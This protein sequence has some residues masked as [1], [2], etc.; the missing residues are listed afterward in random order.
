MNFKL[1]LLT[2]LLVV[3]AGSSSATTQTGNVSA[4][5]SVAEKADNGT[6]GERL[7]TGSGISETTAAIAER[8]RLAPA[9][10]PHP[11]HELEYPDRSNL[12]QNPD[13]PA[14]ASFPAGG[15]AIGSPLTNIHSTTNSFDGATLTD[16]GAFPPDSM[17]TV[18]P[19]QFI[20]FSNGRIRSFTKAGAAD[21]VINANPD[22]FFAS[23]MTPVGGSVVLNFTS[24]PQIRYDRF[25]GRW[26]MSIID[27][28]CTINT[29]AT[30]APNRWLLAVSNAAS[31]GT[32][33]GATVWTFFQFQADASNF[34]DY[35]SLGI[36]VNALYVGCNMFTG[37]GAFVGTNGYVVQK[38]SA[39]GAGPIVVTAFANMAAGA[40]AGP[41]SPRGV[42]NFDASATE[43][44]FVGPD[45]ATF[46]TIMFRR[47]SNPGSLTP[48]IS[49]NIGVAVPT[50]TLSGTQATRLVQHAGNTGGNNGLL[51]SL[52]DRFFQAMIRNGHLWTAHHFTVTN[53]GVA[54][55]AAASRNATR[56]YDFQNLTTTPTLTQ[57]GTVFDNAATRAAARQYWI[58]SITATG[59][60]HAV[61]AFTMGGTP[62]G[63]TPAYTGRLSGDTLGTM[64]GPPGT[65]VVS[66]GTT[67]ANYNPPS[68]PGG[69]SGRRWGDY[70]FTVVDPLDDMSVWTIQE[71][72]QASNSYAVRVGQLLAPPPATPTCSGSPI[73]FPSGTGN[74]VI[75]ATSSAGSGFYDPG[76]NL[77]APALPFN[78]LTASMTNGTVNSATYNSPTQVTLNITA[79]TAGLQNVTITNP[80]GQNVVASGCINVSI[81]THTVTPSSDV[82]GSISPNT[83]VS[84]NDGSTTNFTLTPNASY[85]IASVGGTCGGGLVG[86][87][88]TTAAVT[89]DCT[90]IANFAID[91]FTVTPS[92]TGNG[93]IAPNT[94]QIVNSG[95]T[96]NFTLTPNAGNHIVDVTGTCG[97]GL[98]GNVFTTAAVAANCSVSANFAPDVVGTCGTG[99]QVEAVATAGTPGPTGYTTL[100]GA[101]DAINAGTHQG[102]ITVNVCADTTETASA[103][104]NASG[105]GGS[106]YTGIT[107]NPAGG[108]ARTISGAIA[109]GSPLVDL[110][111]ASNVVI[112]G[113]NSGGNTLTLANTTAAATAG[114][115]TI[116]FI[117]GAKSNT[118]TRTTVLGSSTAAVATAAGN[119]LF[120][121]STVAGGNSGNMISN[122]DF[123]PAGANLPT[124]M[125]SAVGTT[126]NF[127]TNNTIDTNLIHDFFSPTLSVS[128]ISVQAGNSGWAISNNRIYQTAPRTF[129]ATALRYAG[130]TLNGSTTLGNY[131]VTGNIIGFGAAN[132]TGTTTISGSTNTFRGIDT[133]TLNITVPTVISGNFVSGINQTTAG[134]GTTSSAPFVGIMLGSSD[135]LFTATGNQVGSLDGSSTIAVTSNAASLAGWAVGIFNF[136]FQ[137]TTISNNQIGSFALGGSATTAV[138]FRGIYVNTGTGPT[139]LATINNN[140]VANVSSTGIATYALYGIQTVSAPVSITGNLIHDLAGSSSGAGVSGTG[141]GVATT[142]TGA[143]TVARNVLHTLR[144]DAGAASNSI[145]S[146]DLSF[147]TTS[148]NVV[149]RN[150]VH[151]IEINSTTLTSQTAGIVARAGAATYRNNIVRLGVDHNGNSITPGYVMYGIFDNATSNNFYNN[152]V[153]IGGSGVASASNTFALVSNVAAA[154]RTYVDN[155]LWNARSNASG[156]AKN[157]AISLAAIAGATTNYNDLYASGSGGIT[158]ALAGVDQATLANWQAATTQDANSIAADPLFAAPNGTAATVDLHL[159]SG[160]PASGAGTPLAGVVDDFDGDARPAAS[161]AIGAD[162]PPPHTVTPSV[163]TAAGSI[164][165]STPQIVSDGGTPS[166]TLTP[167]PGNHI[168]DVTGTCGGSLVGNVFT[169]DRVTADCTVIANFAADTV[170]H[171]VTPSA[172]AN[173]SITPNTPV[174]VND[175]DT[176]NFTLTP[177]ASYRIASVGGTCGGSLVGNLYTTNPVTADCTVIANFV[178]DTYTVTPSSGGN[179]T[180]SPNTPQVVNN[181][182][183]TGFTLTPN[184]HY[185]IGSVTGTC[186]GSLAGNVFTT[187]AVTADCTVIANFA[188]DTYTVTTNA[189]GGSGTIT[190][191]SQSVDYGSAANFVLTPAAGY[192]VGSVTGNS[193]TV[194]HTTGN[195]WVSSPITANCSVTA[196]FAIDKFTV[197]ASVSG[198]NGTITPASQLVSSGSTAN[199]V[200][201]PAQGYHVASVVGDTCTVT[202]DTGNNWVSSAITTDCAVT[203]TFGLNVLVFTT[204][205]VDVTQGY[206]LATVVVTEEDGSGNP[207]SDSSTVDFT[208]TACGGP[209][210]IGSVAMVNGVATLNSSQVF[211]TVATGLTITATNIDTFASTASAG[212]NVVVNGDLV[213]ADGFES[214]RL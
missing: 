200:V 18:G 92:V 20:V 129:T 103:A 152:S 35:P 143:S 80:D 51:D 25:T 42:D 15:P 127:N 166:F 124:K 60:G 48:T 117:E 154:A 72:N 140:T 141:I 190:P 128:G 206:T 170:T 118:V 29:C 175:G 45:N 100:K 70:S 23:V 98:V 119:I 157:Y 165:P 31:N 212:F 88:F 160:G 39:L 14:I 32:I 209:I 109:A 9:S 112:D 211:Y 54:S 155:I 84:V 149:E 47:I 104:L 179:G 188:I 76:T 53:L 195:N 78:H 111:G 95:A 62:V 49:A 8:Q 13:A 168:V 102:A 162:E 94:P 199:F 131:S 156:T 99:F 196:I 5:G 192:H 137:A 68:D 161:P 27:V 187:A 66:F 184:A 201:T 125:I 114:T 63:A 37:A 43:G 12:P 101:F 189:I 69:G 197:T 198:G 186:G 105:T 146:L 26:F 93:A 185:H 24:D 1:A 116:R 203:A 194:S 41:E 16:T 7:P 56:W 65:S 174:I 115:S 71:Y 52:D 2:A 120:S 191:P 87:V 171:T 163:G 67:T 75:N 133:V 208:I 86:N 97:G 176:T 11:D 210:N 181:G 22:V 158:G 130:I 77:P 64:A 33:S 126:L 58:P 106:S 36:D 89:A 164:S 205:P 91:T 59:Q 135:G 55:T 61:V 148:T 183:T 110:V 57:S 38:T 123:G 17:G 172:G 159:L 121:T 173:G 204:Q 21:G 153:Y 50:T 4:P 142:S 122:N 79:S 169:T 44:Y 177:N 150:L 107:V 139:L 113:L 134:T 213:F 82:N 180:I 83:P 167:D 108:A 73:A 30:T 96:P 207:V 90:V 144:N 10:G 81:P 193:C 145:Y 28:P 136:S 3:S 85:H 46:S 214:C 40:G 202:L 182:A 6:P 19:T 138:A 132:G 151:S 178:L 34:C 74:V 147:A